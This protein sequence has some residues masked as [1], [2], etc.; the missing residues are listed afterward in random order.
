[1]AANRGIQKLAEGNEN[2]IVTG[3]VMDRMPI[4]DI[5]NVDDDAEGFDPFADITDDDIDDAAHIDVD[6]GDLSDLMESL[7]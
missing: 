7:R 2:D 4:D 5:D 6:D 1:M 3:C